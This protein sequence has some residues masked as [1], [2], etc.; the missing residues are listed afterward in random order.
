MPVCVL[1]QKLALLYL[2]F[3]INENFLCAGQIVEQLSVACLLAPACPTLDKPPMRARRPASQE[4]EDR[5]K[6]EPLKRTMALDR[7]L[8]SAQEQLGLCLPQAR[9]GAVEAYN[10]SINTYRKDHTYLHTRET[11]TDAETLKYLS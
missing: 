1:A 11:V 10:C 8:T 7:I 2:I 3:L 5:S 4:R 9:G 6:P